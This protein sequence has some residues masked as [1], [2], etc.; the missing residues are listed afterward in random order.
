MTR[1]YLILG[2]M[3]NYEVKL[4]ILPLCNWQ[5]VREKSKRQGVFELIKIIVD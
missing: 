2:T 1:L 3:S 5:Q 4:L